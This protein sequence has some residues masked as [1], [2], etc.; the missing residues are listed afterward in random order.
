[1]KKN[2]TNILLLL[3]FL[4][5]G[6]SEAIAQNHQYEKVL[7]AD[8]IVSCAGASLGCYPHP[9]TGEDLV[10]KEILNNGTVIVMPAGNG[11]GSVNRSYCGDENQATEHYPFN[12]SYDERV[13]VVIGLVPNPIF[14]YFGNLNGTSYAAPI[15]AGACA[16]LKSINKD[17][18]PDEIQYFIKSTADPVVDANDYPG[19]LGAGRLNVYHAVEMANNC[20]QG[21]ISSNQIW[22]NDTI[23][24]CGDEIMQG[25]FTVDT[26]FLGIT[27]V[28]G[29]KVASV[30]LKS[31]RGV[32][33][34]NT[35]KYPS[36]VYNYTV[37]CGNNLME[38]L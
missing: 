4:I 25:T 30:E 29:V 14:P 36:G 22:N 34:I 11:Y 8:I 17:F 37:H 6:V 33:E 20:S 21:I 19:M 16:L 27:N 23:V 32:V 31:G 7:K 15:V 35:D 18:T 24:V 12:S 9:L 38:Y 2:I 26:S 1:M 10:M 5:Y 28:L 13:I 3:P